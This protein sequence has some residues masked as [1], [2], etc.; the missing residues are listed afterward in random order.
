M[1]LRL[2]ACVKPE[3]Q[4]DKLLMSES[5]QQH[6]LTIMLQRGQTTLFPGNKQQ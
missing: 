4:H 2:K 1:I 3:D 5:Q 6:E